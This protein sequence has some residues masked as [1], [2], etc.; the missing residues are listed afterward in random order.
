MTT[1]GSGE[2]VLVIDPGFVRTA[3]GQDGQYGQDGHDGQDGADGETFWNAASGTYLTLGRAMARL[4]SRFAVPSTV[5]AALAP[6]G[7]AAAGPAGRRAVEELEARGL[8]VAHRPRPDRPP[9]P[10]TAADGLFG[11]PVMSLPEATAGDTT[12][13][14]VIGMPYDVGTTYRPGARF[15]PDYIRRCSTSL[16]SVGSAEKP[17]GRYDPVR[18][19]RVL[20]GVRIADLANVSQRVHT[21]NGESFDH[22]QRL[23]HS[24]MAAGRFAVVLGGDHSVSLPAIRGALDAHGRLG[25]LHIDAHADF[26]EPRAGDWAQE[27]HHGNFM[28]W[29]VGD[30]RVVRV[31]QFGIRQL[32]GHESGRHPRVT[33][34]PGRSAVGAEA[35]QL[36]ADLPSDIP[37]Y[38]TI[39]VDGLDPTALPDTGTPLPGGFTHPELVALLEQL[40][41]ARRVVGM[42]VT[43]LIPGQDDRSGLVVSDLVLRVLDAS[44]RQGKETA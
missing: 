7:A 42:D 9:A 29:I 17:A 13:A 35:A 31:G 39:D 30:E 36:L 11:A 3:R 2:R 18:G 33:V 21:R 43:E 6:L 23:T 40:C 37:Y 1:E 44:V 34:W 14:V 4:A 15:A 5:D 12:D 24:V 20:D 8:L 27:C 10:A 16:F 26:A 22:L 32:T 25:V 41:G 38:L 28:S 19:R